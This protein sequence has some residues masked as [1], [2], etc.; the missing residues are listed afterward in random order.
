MTA[1]PRYYLNARL[2][3]AYA[4]HRPPVHAAIWARVA[5]ASAIEDRVTSA[6]DIGCGAGA[7]TAALAAYAQA[8]TGLDP[9]DAMLRRAR[10]ALPDV[11]F[12]QGRA[13]ALPLE[14]GAYALVAA[15][16]SLNYA[17]PS[18]A[19]A[20]ISR[21]LR[22]LGRFV[23][24]DFSTGHVDAPGQ[25]ASFRTF[26]ER[27]AS[28]PGYSLDLKAL[29][30]VRHA[31]RLTAWEEFEL[32][33]PMSS[34]AYL[35]YVLGETSVEAAIVAGMSESEARTICTEAFEPLFGGKDRQ[36]R[37]RAIFAVAQKSAR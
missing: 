20:E 19:L 24:Y 26:Q 31:L 3:D 4:F 22:P 30:Y 21:V 1:D 2:A 37:F 14:D 25:A 9:S 17:D 11:L 12:V 10:E 28:L 23:A 34:E 36:V 15:A 5:A 7:S 29:P 16:G 33:M 18:A 13:D 8:V 6:L 32:H 35:D 27:F